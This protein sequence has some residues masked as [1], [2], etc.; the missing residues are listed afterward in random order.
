MPEVLD[1]LFKANLTRPVV[2]ILE[3]TPKNWD[4][5]FKSAGDVVTALPGRVNEIF[6]LGSKESYLLSSPQDFQEKAPGWFQENSRRVNLISPVYTTLMN[7]NFNGTAV[8][9]SSRMPYDVADWEEN[10]ILRMT[11]FT[12]I[13]PATSPHQSPPYNSLS[14][15]KVSASDIVNKLE[16]PISKIKV[17]GQGFVPLL[18][19]LRTKGRIEPAYQN[20]QFELNIIPEENNLILHLKALCNQN[21]LPLA[22]VFR[23]R[24]EDKISGETEREWL[25]MPEWEKIPQSLIP[26]IQAANRQNDFLC[27]QCGESHR[28]DTLICPQGNRILSNLPLNTLILFNT[29]NLTYLLLAKRLYAYPLRDNL[30]ITKE[31]TLYEFKN[32]HWTLIRNVR[33]YD[34]VADGILALF[35]KI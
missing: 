18:F 6:F 9:F 11:L 8:V 2:I 25:N 33:Y 12:T 13:E 31:G 27:P 35:H 23:K 26:V 32:N 28:F 34:E 21:S 16:N 19:E 24:N 17:S 7:K 20:N 29:Q 14:L 3:P 30:I 15:N 5:I 4:K 10:E 22:Y 1:I